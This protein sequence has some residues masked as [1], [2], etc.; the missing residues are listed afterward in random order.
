[1]PV[2]F[3]R[4]FIR[5]E[6]SAGIVLFFAAVLAMIV[7]NTQLSRYYI[8]FFHAP[9]QLSFV[10][11]VLEKPLLLWINEG[12]MSLFF[13]LVGLEIKREILEGELNSIKK[14]SLPAVAAIGGMLFPAAIY[15]IMNWHDPVV[16]KGWAIP[17]ATDT[18]FSLGILSLLGNRVP[19][20]LKIF[21]TALAIFDDIGAIIIM[22]IFYSSHISIILLFLSL[23]LISI[24]GL[25]NFLG[26]QRIGPY[27]LVG[28]ILWVCVLKSGVHA[29][30]A[31][32][33]LAFMIPLKN[34]NNA[35]KSLLRD[36]E[37][38]LH[39]WVAFAVLPLFA[40]ANAGVSLS[41]TTWHHWVSPMPLGIAL[42]LFFGKQIGIWVST[43]LAAKAG[44][45]R[46]P[47]NVTLAGLYGM[48]LIAG[49]GFTMSL[50]I[51]TLAFHSAEP[52][53]TLIR[54][55][56]VLGS[57]FSGFL[58]YWVLRFAYSSK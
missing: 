18:A 45:S 41:G 3:I 14:A 1:M 57:L 53:A 33:I 16:L 17:I 11:I 38:K 24:L 40:F 23:L 49:V 28:F 22:A 30:L 20:S 46:L 58:G 29:T 15:L 10:H 6:S 2:R 13:L 26:L 34:E 54:M 5:L 56:V 32:I 19:V 8:L 4:D 52:F 37:K 27:F 50:F 42:G 21:L 31:G 55:G 39:P 47:E 48:S 43:F 35:A 51:G 25:F 12:F 36:L 44:L 9:I 7:D